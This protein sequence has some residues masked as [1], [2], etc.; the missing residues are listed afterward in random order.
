MLA[1]GYGQRVKTHA[2]GGHARQ[3]AF[4]KHHG[5]GKRFPAFRIADITGHHR[6]LFLRLG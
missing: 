6:L 2:V 1:Q 3:T 4:Q 5:L